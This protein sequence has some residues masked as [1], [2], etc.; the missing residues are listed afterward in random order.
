MSHSFQN[1]K[2]CGCLV[3]A[4]VRGPL[5]LKKYF[6]S[7]A[8]GMAWNGSGDCIVENTLKDH[9]PERRRSPYRGSSLVYGTLS[10]EYSPTARL[11]GFDR[12]Q[13]FFGT[14]KDRLRIGGAGY[15]PP[16]FLSCCFQPKTL[17]FAP[18][19]SASGIIPFF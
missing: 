3:V 18:S 8:A 1:R 7:L 17:A 19:A 2:H 9:P 12:P 5:S 10:G 13:I 16:P 15:E 14:R 6:A 11:P 4:S